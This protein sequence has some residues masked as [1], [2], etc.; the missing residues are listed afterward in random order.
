MGCAFRDR[1]GAVT[2]RLPETYQWL[3]VPEQANPQAPIAWQ[4]VRLAGGGDGLAP[5]ASKRLRSD[6]LLVTSLGSTILRKHLDDVPLWRGDHVSIHQLVEDFARYPYL[7][8]L[9]GPEVLVQAIR[10]GVELLTW[11]LDTFAYA[12]SY[13][14]AANRYRGLRGGQVVTLTA[15]SLGLL[16]KPD[17][18]WQQMQAETPSAA[19]VSTPAGAI[20]AGDDASISPQLPGIVAPPRPRRFHGTV[21]LDP[22]RLGRDASRIADEVVAHLAGQ[23]G[24]EVQVTL[25]IE[26]TLPDG[27]SEQIVRT[28]TENSRTLKFT[29]HGFESE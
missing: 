21:H 4:A 16:V 7:P 14:E 15:D 9:V 12:E 5:R 25:E 2:A 22:T 29:S 3:L 11:R 23:V 26:A 6:D 27:A 8:R 17:V 18:A 24:A 13:D 19:P 28:V 1:A 10:D 20:G